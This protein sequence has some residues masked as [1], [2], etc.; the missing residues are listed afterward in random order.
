MCD[1]LNTQ[2]TRSTAR[3]CKAGGEDTNLTT[4]LEIVKISQSYESGKVRNFYDKRIH[5]N[6]PTVGEN[7][8]FRGPTFFQVPNFSLASLAIHFSGSNLS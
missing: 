1:V 6:N 7:S 2:R 8:T 5:N 3:Y 4:N